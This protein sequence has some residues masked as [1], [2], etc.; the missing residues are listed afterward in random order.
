MPH[1]CGSNHVLVPAG[2]Y[3]VGPLFLKSHI[4]IEFRKGAT[5]SLLTDRKRAECFAAG[6]RLLDILRND[7]REFEYGDRAGHFDHLMGSDRFRTGA[8][9]ADELIEQ[10]REQSRE[11]RRSV[12]EFMLYG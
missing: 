11:F 6:I 9:S 3:R 2:D 5:L 10:G 1:F 8:V 7:C 12:S 4:T